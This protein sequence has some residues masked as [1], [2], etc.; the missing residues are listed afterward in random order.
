MSLLSQ[1][2]I[3]CQSTSTTATTTAAIL[4]SHFHATAH[5]LL[6]ISADSIICKLFSTATSST[7]LLSVKISTTDTPRLKSFLNCLNNYTNTF[8]FKQQPTSVTRSH[9]S[10]T[11]ASRITSNHSSSLSTNIIQ[12]G[13]L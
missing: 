1:Q 6:K 13:L 7:A 10:C 8:I 4:I 11:S 2:H 5:Y 9:V 12:P 3:K